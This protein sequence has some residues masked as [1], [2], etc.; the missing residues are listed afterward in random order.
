MIGGSQAQ[1]VIGTSSGGVAGV[2]SYLEAAIRGCL[3]IY[4]AVLPFKALLVVERNGF[5]VLLTLLA[6]WCLINGRLFYRHTPFAVPLAVYVGWIGITI[7]FAIF[8]DYSL[9]EFGKLLQQVTIFYAVAYFLF[10]PPFR[11]TLYALL[12]CLLA[13]VS[14]NG[15]RQFDLDHP[16]AVV[17]FLS[18]EV[19]LTTFLVMMIPLAAATA[20]VAEPLWLRATAFGT[21][22]IAGIC[23]VSTQSRAG[24]LSFIVE[25]CATTWLIRKR[26]AL[27]LSGIVSAGLIVGFLLTL[28]LRD[29]GAVESG[30]TSAIRV[31]FQTTSHSIIHRFDIWSFS[32]REAQKHWLVGIGYGKDNFLKVYGDER[33]TVPEGHAAVKKSGTHNILLYHALHVGVPGLLF[34]CWLYGSMLGK[35]LHESRRA[36]D[37]REKAVL[38]GMAGTLVGLAV[39]LQFDQMFVG[40]LAIV[41]WVLLALTVMH[42]PSLSR[43]AD[44]GRK[45]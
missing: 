3:L 43:C 40:S 32:L 20:F 1:D 26:A 42:Y 44:L 12:G 17:S 45:A 33:E 29:G 19:W 9:K 14:I 31:P 28:A 10:H 36:S 38:Y 34:F 7:P 27:V 37:W 2:S 13:I 21:L 22:G 11:T 35:T 16:Q 6:L 24:L 15:L 5:L 25:F 4:V 23:L 8:P 41:F 18:S 30:G 39:R